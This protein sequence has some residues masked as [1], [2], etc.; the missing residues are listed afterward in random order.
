MKNFS[1]YREKGETK[2]KLYLSL[3]VC[4]VCTVH[5]MHSNNNKN[6]E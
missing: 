1:P 4:R 2:L 3:C 6:N 5:M